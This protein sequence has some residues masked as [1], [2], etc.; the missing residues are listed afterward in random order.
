M[1]PTICHSW[2]TFPQS[3]E[4]YFNLRDYH[5]V[6]DEIRTLS[7][8]YISQYLTV[9]NALY[10]LSLHKTENVVIHV[11]GCN[12][13][14][15]LPSLYWEELCH[16]FPIKSLDVVFI[17]PEI[18]NMRD[19]LDGILAPE[20]QYASVPVQVCPSCSKN[21]ITRTYGFFAGTYEK[22]Y[23]SNNFKRPTIQVS[24]NSGIAMDIS[25]KAAVQIILQQCSES[26][27]F[28][29]TSPDK[30]EADRDREI[31]NSNT[32]HPIDCKTENNIFHSLFPIITVNPH[33][34]ANVFIY[35]N[36]F[37]TIVKGS[38][39]SSKAIPDLTDYDT[40]PP[41]EFVD[42]DRDE[43]D[44]CG[45]DEKVLLFNGRTFKL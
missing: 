27:P 28:V 21:E 6:P 36:Q 37:V 9:A 3:W 32:L 23:K 11:I 16:L 7:S 5:E 12:D 14:E 30:T 43:D 25:W 20:E 22:F 2:K 45:L 42:E 15:C 34:E 29:F 39:D 4:E 17:G 41:L 44:N 13:Y 24:F 1:S 31:M 38:K 40:M 10:T 35:R 18:N 19:G 26:I 33:A 8:E